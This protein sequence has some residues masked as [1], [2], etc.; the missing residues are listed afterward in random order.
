MAMTLFQEKYLCFVWPC[1]LAEH[2]QVISYTVSG[3]TAVDVTGILQTGV[4]A[5]EETGYTHSVKF[6]AVL[7][8]SSEDIPSVA[9]NDVFITDGEEWRITQ[10]LESGAVSVLAAVRSDLKRAGIQPSRRFS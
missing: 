1:L 4:S 6:N 8:I 9:V 10:V 2:G 3:E 7:K 5:C